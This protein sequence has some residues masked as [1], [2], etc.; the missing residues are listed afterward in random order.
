MEWG[1]LTIIGTAIFLASLCIR[2]RIPS[3]PG[4]IASAGLGAS[5][6]IL[7]LS[8]FQMPLVLAVSI[9]ANVSF[10]AGI[11]DYWLF[12]S[13]NSVKED[14]GA[15]LRLTFHDD[16]RHP[17]ALRLANVATWC[18][19]FT[20]Q[21]QILGQD[22][23][24]AIST[25]AATPKTW[26]IFIAYDRPTEVTQIVASLNAAG[27]PRYDIL[28]STKRACVIAFAGDIPAGDLEID[29]RFCT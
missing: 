16:D 10:L 28:I 3:V 26:A 24:G 11:I 22:D 6:S 27:L 14:V 5:V 19:Y 12:T 4:F 17:T 21:I 15:T 25:I 29:V 7:G 20:P 23:D 8:F 13:A 1:T 9:V 18:A 2:W